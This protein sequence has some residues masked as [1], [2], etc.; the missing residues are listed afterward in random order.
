MDAPSLEGIEFHN[1]SGPEHDP[2][3]AGWLLPRYPR[4]VRSRLESPG[5]L[6]ARDPVGVEMRFASDALHFRVF[7]SGVEQDVEVAVFKGE[8]QCGSFQVPAGRIQGLAFAPPEAMGRLP[9][10]SLSHG[11]F[12]PRVWRVVCN[13]GPVVFHGLETFGAPVR[14]PAPEDKPRL[15]WLAYGSSIT[16]SSRNG[17]PHQ[18]ARRL[19]LDVQNKGLSGSCYI[20]REAADYLASGCDWDLA[21]FELGINM[22]HQFTPE[23]FERRA[24]YL[25][26]RC[27][28]AKPGRP[29]VLITV[30]PNQQDRQPEPDAAG[31]NQEAFRE[32]LRRLAVEFGPQ[33][34]HLIEGSA[35][36]RDFTCLGA[37]LLH[38]TDFGHVL[39]GEHLASALKPV[40]AGLGWKET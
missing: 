7:L 3:R 27:L 11:G 17:Y 39:M 2:G 36:L 4:E 5:F 6:M 40:L 10:E 30:F 19:R 38:P 34:V 21:T 26:E 14:P 12:A 16:H 32:C 13:R 29:L 35:I 22:R 24:R 8:Y 23:E 25:L 28:A 9:A 31:S 33:G 1:C 18:A 20:E 37:D 15:R